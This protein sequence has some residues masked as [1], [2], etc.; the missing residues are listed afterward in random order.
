MMITKNKYLMSVPTC[1][2]ISLLCREG[3][4]YSC[5]QSRM[6][7]LLFR[8]Q[9]QTFLTVFVI[10]WKRSVLSAEDS[11]HWAVELE[12]KLAQHAQCC[13]LSLKIPRRLQ[14]QVS[15]LDCAV[16]SD[17]YLG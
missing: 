5:I 16:L 2:D 6:M 4:G 3:S 17:V 10:H 15:F 1:P 13:S 14:R 9:I 12:L 11:G 7:F 8:N